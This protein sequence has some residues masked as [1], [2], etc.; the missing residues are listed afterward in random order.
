MVLLKLFW[1]FVQIGLFS[2]GGGYAALPLIQQQVVDIHGWLTMTE[3]ADVIT[4]AEMTPGSIS[5]NSATFVGTKIAGMPGAVIATIGCVLPSFVIVLTLAFCYYK[6]KNLTVVQGGALLPA[7]GGS[8]TDC[9]RGFGYFAAGGV[10]GKDLLWAGQPCRH[11]HHF[12]LPVLPAQMEAFPHSDHRRLWRSGSGDLLPDG[13][14]VGEMWIRRPA[15]RT[16]ASKKLWMIGEGD[17]ALP[18]LFAARRR[19]SAI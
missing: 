4:I 2:I 19:K 13:D 10:W 14:C 12:G 9:Q 11:R 16:G 8:L 18:P 15:C 6:Y 3:F 5:I 1:S 7:A 17:C